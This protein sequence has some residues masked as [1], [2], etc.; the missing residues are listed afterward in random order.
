MQTC[1]PLLYLTFFYID[2]LVRKGFWQELNL[3]DL[4]PLPDNY[5]A[6]LWSQK[7]I[8]IRHTCTLWKLLSLTKFSIASML[9]WSLFSVFFTL[10]PT[11]AMNRLLAYLED[12]AQATVRPYILVVGLLVAPVLNSMFVQQY[13][14]HSIQLT[15]NTKS[16]L[17]QALYEKTLKVRMAGAPE[18]DDAVELDRFGRIHN[19]MSSDM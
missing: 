19:L 8:G 13:L 3:E 18:G 6:K 11:M 12:P 16:A 9:L 5:R 14:V 10:G 2:R 1:T 4:P 7:F 17:V 15:A